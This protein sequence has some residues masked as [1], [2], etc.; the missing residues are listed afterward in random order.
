MSPTR[1]LARTMLAGVFITGGV[2]TLRQ[3]GPRVEQV[4]QSGLVEKLPPQVPEQLR[5]PEGLVRA[6]AV[7]DIVGGLALLRSRTPRLASL[8]LMLSMAPMTFV[9]HPFWKEKDKQVKQQQQMHFL[10][11]AGIFGGLL[12]SASDTGGRESVPHAVGRLSRKAKKEAR[13]AG[14]RASDV[15]PTS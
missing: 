15:L 9:G 11:N 6:N 4:R 5:T 10:K 2:N 7:A 8:G 12:L 3:P 1:R 14:K 13:K